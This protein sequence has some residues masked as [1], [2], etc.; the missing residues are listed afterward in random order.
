MNKC[1]QIC[2]VAILFVFVTACKAQ[3]RTDQPIEK[4]SLEEIVFLESHAIQEVDTIWAN[5]APSRITRK[6]RK[7]KEGNLLF[8]AY[9]DI[10]R[11]DGVSFTNFKKEEGFGSYDAFD[12][13]E[14]KNGSIWIEVLISEYFYTPPLPSYKLVT[15][16]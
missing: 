8:A 1:L 6:I 10:I 3:N 16:L 4:I 2:Y 5:N 9:E 15:K 11:Y 7:D 12:V 13:W 14:D